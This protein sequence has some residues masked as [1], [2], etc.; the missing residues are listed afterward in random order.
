[1]KRKTITPAELF[2][3]TKL[4]KENFCATNIKSYSIAQDSTAKSRHFV[5]KRLEKNHYVLV[6]HDD[7]KVIWH[8]PKMPSRYYRGDFQLTIALSEEEEFILR[9]F[10][11]R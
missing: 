11:E 7:E 2:L 3:L 9:Y 1:M 8:D 10:A 4:R 6:D 5:I